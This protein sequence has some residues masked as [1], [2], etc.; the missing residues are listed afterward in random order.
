MAEFSH[1][2]VCRKSVRSFKSWNLS[3][4]QAWLLPCLHVICNPCRISKTQGTPNLQTLICPVCRTEC[5]KNT[6]L[7]IPDS[8]SCS[9]RCETLACP[10]K[11]P[12]AVICLSCNEK[13]CNECG[14]AHRRVTATS[15][16]VLKPVMCTVEE[17]LAEHCRCPVHT[18]LRAVCYCTCGLVVCP[19]CL[20]VGIH[21]GP[22]HSVSSILQL[23]PNATLDVEKVKSSTAQELLQVKAGISS[24]G[25]R[26]QMFVE[27]IDDLKKQIGN[28]VVKACNAIVKRGWDIIN[29]LD[30]VKKNKIEELDQIN[31]ALHLQ[32]LRFNRVNA[33]VDTVKDFEEPTAVVLAQAYL[34]NC[35]NVIKIKKMLSEKSVKMAQRPLQ[36][37]A[38]FNFD[39]IL[40]MINKYGQIYVESSDGLLVP[41]E[42]RPALK[43]P[44]NLFHFDTFADGACSQYSANCDPSSSTS[45]Q[46]HSR[47]K[48]HMHPG[49]QN[50][51]S[52]LTQFR[53]VQQQQQRF[54]TAQEAIRNLAQAKT[55]LRG[56]VQDTRSSVHPPN[57]RP[58]IVGN[59]LGC[60]SVRPQSSCVPSPQPITTVRPVRYVVPNGQFISI[61]PRNPVSLANPIPATTLME[62]LNGSGAT[63]LNSSQQYVIAPRT[64][65]PH[66]TE[67]TRKEH[68]KETT[69]VSTRMSEKVKSNNISLIN[70]KTEKECL[71]NDGLTSSSVNANSAG[72]GRS[73]YSANSISAE[74]NQLDDV[75]NIQFSC[76]S[77]SNEN[78][79]Q[80]A[81]S[82]SDRSDEVGLTSAANCSSSE[83]KNLNGQ[84]PLNAPGATEMSFNQTEKIDS[85]SEHAVVCP[86]I[87]FFEQEEVSPPLTPS[88][89]VHD[90]SN[91]ENSSSS[92][93]LQEQSTSNMQL[94]EDRSNQLQSDSEDR[95][96][97]RS[98]VSN[99]SVSE[100]RKSTLKKS[101]CKD[102]QNPSGKKSVV[103]NEV[104]NAEEESNCNRDD[105]TWED[106]CYVCQQGCDDRTGSLGCCAK[107]P[108]VFHN[109][110]HIPAIKEKMENLPDEW[111]CSLCVPAQPLLVKSDTMGARERLLCC[112]VLLRCFEDHENVQPFRHPVSRSITSYHLIIKKPMD[113][114][115]IARRLKEKA[116]DGFTDVSQFILSMNLVF[117]NCSTFNHPDTE[118]AIAGRKVYQY[119]VR[120]VDEY[121]PCMKS[122]LWLY[123]TLYSESKIA[124][125]KH[126]EVLGKS[127]RSRSSDKCAEETNSKRPRREVRR[128]SEPL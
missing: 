73:Q 95:G 122:M 116:K 121:L 60:Y 14:M 58:P 41:V 34:N 77:S 86:P 53:S 104:E 17:I 49:A 67:E 21:E 94:L 50:K 12:A 28:N 23:A 33:F 81:I 126:K 18:N 123:L 13:L 127:A 22:Q 83:P 43:T 118:V 54:M 46:V 45:A 10:E 1:C 82:S 124:A 36:V 15:N 106:Y 128:D 30:F 63:N 96:L 115:T 47:L 5:L 119:Y 44:S 112:K 29:T 11:K 19:E 7:L 111:Q 72:G 97:E 113:F 39:Q 42:I 38:K 32:Q 125:A 108:R 120:A 59:S 27:K 8:K 70:P 35:V 65:S 105:M 48:S 89:S 91:I 71:S 114:G 57:F 107:C 78:S 37:E 98:D 61:S 68:S 84:S 69:A 2:D 6:M 76:F 26:K 88:G 25:V 100:S 20:L 40:S 102:S 99:V 80:N 117:E 62:R 9:I 110:C 90:G 66:L 4:P 51:H 103:E 93:R 55:V 74:C 56:C 52:S 31:D 3:H 85:E 16:H 101:S 109:S 92:A 87:S 75:K 79:R 64:T 24:L